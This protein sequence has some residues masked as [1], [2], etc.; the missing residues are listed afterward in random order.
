MLDSFL[1]RTIQQ[2]TSYP[3]VT[4][5]PACLDQKDKRGQSS[6]FF[7]IVTTTTTLIIIII[8]II[9][10]LSTLFQLLLFFSP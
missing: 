7:V 2:F 4:G 3:R 5:P 10:R 9:I 6:T 8:I 1:P